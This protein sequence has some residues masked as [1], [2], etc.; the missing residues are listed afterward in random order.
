MARCGR[1][2]SKLEEGKEKKTDNDEVA[3]PKLKEKTTTLLLY[4]MHTGDIWYHL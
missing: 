1:K 3:W 2:E 4:R